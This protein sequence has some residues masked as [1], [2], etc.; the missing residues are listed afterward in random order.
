M[1]YRKLT[2]KLKYLVSK[3]PVVAVTGPRQSGKT[4]LLKMTFPDMIYVS[5]ENPDTRFFA[6]EDPRGFLK[7]YSNNVI[8][9]EIQRVPKLFSYIQEKVD[10]DKGKFILSGSQNFLLHQQISQTLAGRV[11]IL[12]LLP[13]SYQELKNSNIIYDNYDDYI[14]KGFYPR[15]YDLELHPTDWY[16]NY[17]QTYL[18]KDVR[19]IKNIKDLNKFQVFL[20]LVAG[21]VGQIVNFSSLSNDLGLTV[22]TVRDWLSILESSYI[23]YF[24]KPHHRNHNKRVIKM[25]KLYFYDIGLVSSLLGVEYKEQI[26]THYLKG[27]LFE[28]LI[29]TEMLKSRFNTGKESN[30][31]YWRD[32]TGNELD[33]LSENLNVVD[34]F[35]LKSGKTITKS[36]FKGINYYNKISKT[37]NK[38][39][40]IYGGD[41]KEIRKDTLVLPWNKL[42]D[43]I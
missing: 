25:P 31:Y 30:L 12:K 21:R 18:E 42:E 20:K 27:A 34:I 37:I 24:L 16:P 8:F 5:L 1:I 23:I 40:L 4:T 41:T 26:N 36:F 2:E 32:K 10:N 14:F 28:N 39:F 19:S 6:I 15:I 43:I 35:E 29:I 3:F 33:I 9:D 17:I 7:T 38:S 22:P 11:A 13:F